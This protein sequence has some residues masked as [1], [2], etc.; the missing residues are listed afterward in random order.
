VRNYTEFFWARVDWDQDINP[1]NPPFHLT[2]YLMNSTKD[3]LSANI[4]QFVAALKQDP[5]NKNISASVQGPIYWL[6]DKSNLELIFSYAQAATLT[7]VAAGTPPSW[8]YTGDKTPRA[9]WTDNEG[10]KRKPPPS[11]QKTVTGKTKPGS[12][13]ITLELY[14]TLLYQTYLSFK[15][16]PTAIK[17]KNILN[18]LLAGKI[19]REQ[20]LALVSKLPSVL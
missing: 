3:D 1:P 8:I 20:A 11:E 7:L 17:V 6:M 19:S 15:M 2:D 16:F 13:N 9:G 12:A 10:V 18:D 14:L 5:T 4:A